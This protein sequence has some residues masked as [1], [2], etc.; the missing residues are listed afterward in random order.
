MTSKSKSSCWFEQKTLEIDRDPPQKNDNL[1]NIDYP[2]RLHIDIHIDYVFVPR[3][4]NL[5]AGTLLPGHAVNAASIMAEEPEPFT[6][7]RW[8]KNATF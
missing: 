5:G 6:V 3:A 7:P 4:T 1:Y 2:Y 8:P